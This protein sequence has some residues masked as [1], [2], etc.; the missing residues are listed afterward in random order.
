MKND[1]VFA[2][3][4]QKYGLSEEQAAAFLELAGPYLKPDARPEYTLRNI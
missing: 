1:Q 2:R 4:E 3:V